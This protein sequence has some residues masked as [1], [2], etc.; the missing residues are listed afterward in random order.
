[1]PVLYSKK[2]CTIIEQLKAADLGNSPMFN[3]INRVCLRAKILSQKEFS[4]AENI[5]RARNKIHVSALTEIDNSYDQEK[6]NQIFEQA[7]KIINKVEKKIQK[8]N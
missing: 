7:R 6:L 5:M 2:T 4:M 8:Y 3:I 1:M